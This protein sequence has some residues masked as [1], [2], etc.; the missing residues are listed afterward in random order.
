VQKSDKISQDD[1]VQMDRYMLRAW[2]EINLYLLAFQKRCSRST[3]TAQA[4]ERYR[5]YSVWGDLGSS[6]GRPDR[7]FAAFREVS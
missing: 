7:A 1:V 3:P 4:Y 6:A 2:V 5:V